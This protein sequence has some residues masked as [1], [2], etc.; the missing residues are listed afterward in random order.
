MTL[1]L[2]Y[3]PSGTYTAPPTIA[4][5]IMRLR[6]DLFDRLQN[7]PSGASQ[8][9][10]D[11]D[12]QRAIDRA[13]D[14][15]SIVKPLIQA[16]MTSTL[17]AT[18]AYVLPVGA[19][20]IDTVEYP[21]GKWPLQYVSFE[22][23]MVTPSLGP[24]ATAPVIVDN[25]AGLMNGGSWC[26]AAT[27][28]KSG[29]ETLLGPQSNVLVQGVNRQIAVSSIPLGPP[30]TVG[31]NLYRNAASGAAG[32]WIQIAQILDN[33]TTTFVDNLNLPLS[34][35]P[36]AI[37]TTANL[38]QF[39]MKLD[40]F[41]LPADTTGV[42]TVSYAGKHVM[43]S[44]GTS[45]AEQHHDAVLLGAAAYAVLAYAAPTMDL[46]EYQDGELRDRVNEVGIPKQ[47]MMYGQALLKLFEDRL[48]V[49]KR[50]N[51]AGAAAVA[52][53]GDEPIRWQRT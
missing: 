35:V 12:L 45:I 15:Y 13:I 37:D 4:D 28:L 24:V 38:V 42:I 14:R 23:N 32:S 6:M 27:F 22:D 51:N 36:P 3:S 18:R 10:A 43:T 29:G 11:D 20:W 16:V 44:A 7:I 33:V 52:Q 17:P 26:Y 46:F 47:W 8:R 19:F 31:R 1:V 49:I 53:W 5:A 41:K 39:I 2:Q 21:T 9:W 50:Q 34:A 48:D 40:S 30:G 25:G